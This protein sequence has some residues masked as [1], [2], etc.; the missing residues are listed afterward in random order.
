MGGLILLE[1]QV[2]VSSN[3][4]VM[5]QLYGGEISDYV[6]PLAGSCS[7][8]F[9]PSG[10]YEDSKLEYIYLAKV[11]GVGRIDTKGLGPTTQG[12]MSSN[13]ERDS[14]FSNMEK[15]L[16][17]T[18]NDLAKTYDFV[19]QTQQSS[20]CHNGADIQDQ[21]ADD[22][23]AAKNRVMIAIKELLDLKS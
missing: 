15:S 2:G 13:I 22:V 19:G 3:A 4:E 17:E 1:V 8:S 6:K 5:H 7:F 18:L 21:T 14:S 11:K 23:A 10:V 20:C 16:T 12:L 9:Y